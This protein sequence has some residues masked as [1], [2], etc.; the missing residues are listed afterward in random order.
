[1]IF[2]GSVQNEV[3]LVKFSMLYISFCE[4]YYQLLLLCFWGCSRHFKNCF[5]PRSL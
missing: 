1:M 5:A 2:L 4:D 3:N